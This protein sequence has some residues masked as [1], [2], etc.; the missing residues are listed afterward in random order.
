MS[1]GELAVLMKTDHDRLTAVVK[2]SGMTPQ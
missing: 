2:A 1:L